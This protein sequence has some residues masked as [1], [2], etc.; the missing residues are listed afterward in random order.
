MKTFTMKEF[1]ARFFIS[2]STLIATTAFIL[3]ITNT[4]FLRPYT[5]STPSH[6]MGGKNFSH[7]DF[8]P[9]LSSSF[10]LLFREIACV[11]S[12]KVFV[13]SSWCCVVVG[14]LLTGS[15]FKNNS[16]FRLLVLLLAATCCCSNVVWL[17]FVVSSLL[18]PRRVVCWSYPLEIGDAKNG[19]LDV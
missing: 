8:S 12:A 18:L 15:L 14:L 1:S 11:R 2:Q 3:H 6:L 16:G 10:P 13:V 5:F 7:F 4:L 19:A 9:F 17:C